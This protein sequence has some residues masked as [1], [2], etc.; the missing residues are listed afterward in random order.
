LFDDRFDDREDVRPMGLCPEVPLPLGTATGWLDVAFLVAMAAVGITGISALVRRGRSIWVLAILIVLSPV[1]LMLATVAWLG[2]WS[3]LADSGR[4]GVSLLVGDVALAGLVASGAVWWR[5]LPRPADRPAWFDRGWW[6]AVSALLGVA[7]AAAFRWHEAG[8][9]S[10]YGYDSAS[11][12]WHDLVIY[13][14]LA[15]LVTY[16]FWPM[17]ITGPGREAAVAL[18]IVWVA[19]AAM[20]NIHPLDPARLHPQIPAGLFVQV[21]GDAG[22]VTLA[23]NQPAHLV[24]P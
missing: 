14:V 10:L 15:T 11:K 24:C 16:V 23:A 21:A 19:T 5:R 9:Y 18:L 2:R 6:L 7:L 12:L 13:P 17:V 8:A 3:A 20:D 4:W 1:S 22:P